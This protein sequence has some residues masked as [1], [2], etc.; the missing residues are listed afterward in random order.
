MLVLPV[1]SGLF[2]ERPVSA[3]AAGRRLHAV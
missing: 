1:Q 3:A 2:A